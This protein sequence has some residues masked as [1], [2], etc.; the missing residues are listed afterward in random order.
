MRWMKTFGWSW[1]RSRGRSQ[2]EDQAEAERGC[3]PLPSPPRKGGGGRT[4]LKDVSLLSEWKEVKRAFLFLLYAVAARLDFV[5]PGAN[6]AGRFAI[7]A[8][9]RPRPVIAILLPEG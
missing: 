5:E 9:T 4:S 7:S 1:T 2:T 3:S 6:A 8:G